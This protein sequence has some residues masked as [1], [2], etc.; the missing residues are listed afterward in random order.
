MARERERAM[1]DYKF[2]CVY[3]YVCIQSNSYSW[4]FDTGREG[5][6]G[7]LLFVM[8][9]L[10]SK[11]LSIENWILGNCTSL[12]KHLSSNCCSSYHQ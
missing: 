12:C 3:S 7:Q 11:E 10:N 1:T 2:Q 9:P 4:Q 6:G 5:E 8:M